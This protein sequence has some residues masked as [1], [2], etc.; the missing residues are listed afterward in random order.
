[1][2]CIPRMALWGGLM[3]GV[4]RSEPKIPPLVIVKTPPSRSARAILPSR[5]FAAVI[6]DGLLDRG[7]GEV[8]AIADDGHHE[9]LL[10]RDGDP[11][12]VEMVLHERVAL[13]L[14]IDRRAPPAGPGRRP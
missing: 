1:M 8:V 11:D 7:D 6:G 10:G 9:S 2:A 13:E 14:G 5:A 12:V 4:E 3:I